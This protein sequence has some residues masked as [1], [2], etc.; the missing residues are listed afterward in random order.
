MP[1]KRTPGSRD[2]PDNL[3]PSPD[4]RSGVTYYRY[5]D[6]R[7]G[8]F[9]GMGT[10]K[11]AAI[12]DAKALNAAILQQMSGARVQALA[13]P[14]EPAGEK[15]SA[16][17]ARHEDIN[18]ARA[19]RGKLAANTIKAKTSNA[20]V[21]RAE[22]GARPIDGI[23]VRELAQLFERYV[24]QGKERR[25]QALR[26]EAIEVWKTAIA[27]GYTHD[28]PAAK[29]RPIDAEVKRARLTLDSFCQIYAAA[30]ELEPCVARS[31]ELGILTAQRREDVAS[32]EFR[33]RNGATG[34][35]E[36]GMLWVIQH[37]TRNRVAIPLD[38]RLDVLGLTLADIVS[39]CRDN[40]VSRY[41]VHHQ[42]RRNNANPGDQVWIDTITK[43]F[44][45]A[46]DL[47]AKR[48]P[49]PL[50]DQDKAPPSYHELRSLAE[51]LYNE[52]G[53]VDTQQLLGHKD[54]RSTA[55][56]KDTRGAEW[57]RVKVG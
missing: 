39:R 5:L 18:E 45:R 25:A 53:N 36:E 54:P 15:F 16:V 38:L 7:T 8:K 12:A 37:K 31:I 22:F 32:L 4:K 19:K 24:E 14:V 35:V 57:V 51:R 52:Q 21:L 34:W 40:I 3:Y 55:I 42:R 41:L 30:Q 1:P 56:Y 2:L 49:V 28:N 26:S 43:H 46:R 11:A 9:H 29:T 23:S 13:A 6:P 33:P 47:A 44:A 17:L 27:E 48:S 20:R 10:D 50:W